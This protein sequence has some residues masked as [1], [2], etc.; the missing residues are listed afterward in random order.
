MPIRH[1][2][3]FFSERPWLLSLLLLIG[4]SI[5]LGMG[6]LRA[7]ESKTE[8]EAEVAPLAKVQYDTFD[9]ILTAKTVDLYGRTAPDKQAKLG[10]EV[11]GKVVKLLV[12]KGASVKKGQAIAQ[13]DKDNLEIQLEQ[14]IANLNVKEKEFKAAKSLKSKGL[15][16]EVAYSSAQASLVKAKTDVSKVRLSLRNSLLKAPFDGIVDHL[17]IEV[18]DYVGVGDPV[19]TVIDLQVLVIEADVSERHVQSLKRGQTAKIRLI[20]GERIE[21][22]LRYLSRVSSVATNTFPIEI[23]IANPNQRVPAGV[24]A[25]VEL[26]LEMKKAIKVSP[27]MLA[28]DEDGNLGV[29]VLQ[30]NRVKFVAIQLVKAVQ[31]GVWLSGLGDSVDIITVGQGFVRDGDDV[32]AVKVD[33]VSQ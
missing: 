30:D 28:L 6:M 29:K 4:L 14:A 33:S 15:Q 12:K 22:T 1:V 2:S 16:G 8:S 11:A 24:S 20:N 7:E 3:R 13:I 9:A 17:F 21:G 26:D 19:A 23:E 32:I 27:A 25:E 18:G 5:W 10:A 31:D